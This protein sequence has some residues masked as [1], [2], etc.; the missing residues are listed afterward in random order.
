MVLVA[1]GEVEPSDLGEEGGDVAEEDGPRAG[2]TST[3]TDVAGHAGVGIT[4]CTTPLPTSPTA[5][6]DEPFPGDASWG[7]T[8]QPPGQQHLP[9][10]AGQWKDPPCWHP[11]MSMSGPVIRCKH[12]YN[13]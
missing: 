2:P 8:A 4:S 3:R 12:I 9:P 1:A 5:D 10:R 6:M 11:S 13:F 7:A